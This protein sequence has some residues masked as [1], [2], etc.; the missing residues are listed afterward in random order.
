[1]NR[2]VPRR[3]C[4]YAARRRR[5]V[6]PRRARRA[7]RAPG[8][9]RALLAALVLAAAVHPPAATSA[10]APR[11]S[12]AAHAVSEP[13][14]PPVHV[15][16]LRGA[17]APAT[18]DLLRRAL[19]EAADAR[20]AALVVE[21]DTP[22]GLAA[23]MRDV[24]QAVLA[25]PVPVVVYVYP[26]GARAASAGAMIAL[27]AH[28][29]AMAP[30]THIGAAHPVTL[31]PGA[32]PDET[33]TEKITNDAAAL[34]RSLATRRG[35]DV[36]WAERIVRESISSTAREAL[37]AG[38]ADCIAP[39][40]D[41]L[42]ETLDGRVV[43]LDGRADTLRTRGV[44]VVRIEPTLRERFLAW[45][46]DPNIAYLLL[47]A[48]IFG[49]LFEFQ[50]PGSIVPGVAGAIAL[51]T[52]AFGLQMLPVDATGV[53]LILLAI[54]LFV[55][56][57]KVT[58]HGALGAAGTVS[59]L[60]GS[61]MLIDSPVPAMRISLRVIVPAVVVVAGGF[62]LV[63]ALAVRAQRA[64]VVTGRDGLVGARGEARS[65]LAPRGTVFVHG[66]YW[67]ARSTR[68]VS[69]G[70]TVIVEDVDGMTLVVRPERNPE[71]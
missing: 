57:V 8:S 3:P 21:M 52:A 11:G 25:S 62:L 67:N 54:A 68:P 24:I 43:D 36:D 12:G 49:L 70:E 48:G 64:R 30:G 47:M 50:H 44:R 27:A 20:S 55:A 4:A 34:A 66:E 42:L 15:V 1:M 63:A 17:V 5:P 46:S 14:R 32:K 37:E 13:E 28:V 58:S 2:P 19:R 23:S 22:G 71:V 26:P 39:D 69:A 16:A 56:E 65:D 41:A 59:L 7:L 33:L 6:H 60:L 53:L 18:R 10:P 40:L 9:P 35:R 31:G 38:V 61:L 51:V 29:L 45:I